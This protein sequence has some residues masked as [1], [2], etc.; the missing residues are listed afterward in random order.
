MLEEIR[1]IKSEKYVKILNRLLIRPL[2]KENF[3]N[4]ITFN[5][6]DLKMFTIR[7]ALNT[8]W[9]LLI[10]HKGFIISSITK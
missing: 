5:A 1:E 9:V 4:N 2:L 7:G 10:I 6:I 8:Y 3:P